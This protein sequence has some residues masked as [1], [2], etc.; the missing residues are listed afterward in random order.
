MM[1]ITRTYDDETTYQDTPTENDKND[2][3]SSD[4]QNRRGV[5][6]ESSFLRIR[7]ARL[8]LRDHSS[9]LCVAISMNRYKEFES[10][11]P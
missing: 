10:K 3:T 2:T 7:D 9:F 11:G 1:M 6:S 5:H 4:L 8:G